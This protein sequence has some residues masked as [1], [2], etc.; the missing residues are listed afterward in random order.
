MLA[1]LHITYLLFAPWTGGFP[2][3][4]VAGV[5]V[6]DPPS[7]K[8]VRMD[9]FCAGR[10]RHAARALERK[11]SNFLSPFAWTRVLIMH[12]AG[13][14]HVPLSGLCNMFLDD[15]DIFVFTFYMG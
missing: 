12:A 11:L 2:R 7:P 5:H 1:A 6:R 3:P 9:V 14:L 10:P 13:I 4:A 15:D 8:H